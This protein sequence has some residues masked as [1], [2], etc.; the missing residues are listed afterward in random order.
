VSLQRCMQAGREVRVQ[1]RRERVR[2]VARR[3]AKY[4][5]RSARC[6]DDVKDVSSYCT[7][8]REDS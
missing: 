8:T 4:C 1:P 6:I 3:S 2:D 7:T 5:V